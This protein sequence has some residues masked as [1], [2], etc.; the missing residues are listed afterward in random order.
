MSWATHHDEAEKYMSAADVA[1]WRGD[2][3]DA[4]KNYVTAARAELLALREVD[5]DKPRTY[6][7]TAVSAAALFYKGKEFAEAQKVARE[8]LKVMFLPDFTK[9]QLEEILSAIRQEALTKTSFLGHIIYRH[10]VKYLLDKLQLVTAVCI[11]IIFVNALLADTL[12]P[13]EIHPKIMNSDEIEYIAF[14]ILNIIIYFLIL[15][16]AVLNIIFER[17]EKNYDRLLRS[18][19]L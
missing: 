9:N 11:A 13:Y 10:S 17:I 5:A 1:R 8:A 2:M 6:G 4:Q 18:I 7:I 15:I 3:A 16:C 12:M 19:Y 14:R